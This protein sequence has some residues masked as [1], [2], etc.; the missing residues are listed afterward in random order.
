MHHSAKLWLL[1]MVYNSVT[2]IIKIQVSILSYSSCVACKC[3]KRSSLWI[4]IHLWIGSFAL[5]ILR[6]WISLDKKSGL[7]VYL[8]CHEHSRGLFSWFYRYNECNLYSNDLP[9][10]SCITGRVAPDF[11]YYISNLSL[12]YISG[13]LFW[14]WNL[15]RKINIYNLGEASVTFATCLIFVCTPPKLLVQPLSSLRCN[16]IH[17]GLAGSFAVGIVPELCVTCWQW[18]IVYRTLENGGLLHS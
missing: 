15:R 2:Y 11:P 17:S 13:V 9:T 18:S 1:R 10:M 8:L 14:A 5:C 6:S 12:K 7:I 3:T 16:V 4:S